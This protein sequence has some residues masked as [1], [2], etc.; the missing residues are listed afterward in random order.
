[1]S[2]ET[3]MDYV[4]VGTGSLA[5]FFLILISRFLAKE[6]PEQIRPRIFLRYSL[7]K[8]SIYILTAGAVFL[9]IGHIGAVTEYG[10]LH[11]IGE[12]VNNVLLFFFAFVLLWVIKPGEWKQK[13]DIHCSKKR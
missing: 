3:I 7:F 11:E 13:R 5:L 10:L 2:V 9:L 1:M 6:S 12:S 8:V 4:Y